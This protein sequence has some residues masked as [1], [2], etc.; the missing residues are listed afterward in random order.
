[1]LD[2]LEPSVLETGGLAMCAGVLVL[3]LLEL[4]GVWLALGKGGRR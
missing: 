1:M 4:R 2:L 3:F